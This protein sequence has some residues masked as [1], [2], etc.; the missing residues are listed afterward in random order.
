MRNAGQEVSLYR[1]ALPQAS[2]LSLAA[3]LMGRLTS[4]SLAAVRAEMQLTSREGGSI[5]VCGVVL[6]ILNTSRQTLSKASPAA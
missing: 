6:S 3:Q 4:P 2:S 5:A 1:G